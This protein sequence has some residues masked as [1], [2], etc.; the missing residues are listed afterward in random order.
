ML[1]TT[2]SAAALAAARRCRACPEEHHREEAILA[3]ADPVPD[4]GAQPPRPGIPG[5]DLDPP[6]HR[7]APGLAVGGEDETFAE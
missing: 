7:P 1:I 2:T 4:L 5:S 3:L 6:A